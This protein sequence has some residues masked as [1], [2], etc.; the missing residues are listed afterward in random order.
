M[1]ASLF[2]YS[3]VA[4]EDVVNLS[5]LQVKQFYTYIESNREQLFLWLTSRRYVTQSCGG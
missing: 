3:F 4:I 1:S 2:L 5:F